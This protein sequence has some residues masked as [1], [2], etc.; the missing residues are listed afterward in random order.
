LEAPKT[1]LDYIFNGDFERP[2]SGSPFDW[3]FGGI[4][5]AETEIVPRVDGTSGR[6]LRVTFANTRVPYR[7]TEK[8]LLLS[9]AT[10]QLA[11]EARALAL[12]NERGLAW[13]IRCVED[14]NVV[15]A[16]TPL[17]KGSTDW[18]AF[19]VEFEVPDLG[20]RAQWMRLELDARVVL[21]QQVVGEVW[22]D[23]LRIERKPDD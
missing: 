8:L 21:E 19:A 22:Y 13:R 12:E 18:R 11:G 6:A 10:Y 2:S 5:G 17:L 15:L 14:E 7:H 1:T 9:P 23:Q 16:S 4:R 20:C 3:R